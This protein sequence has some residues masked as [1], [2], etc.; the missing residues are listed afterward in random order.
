VA[1]SEELDDLV[2]ETLLEDF[3]TLSEEELELLDL[4]CDTE[5]ELLVCEVEDDDFV[6]DSELEEDFV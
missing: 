2:C 1:E 5:D 3:V 6:T 4:V